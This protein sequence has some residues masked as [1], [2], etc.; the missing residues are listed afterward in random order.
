MRVPY[1]PRAS[2]ETTAAL[3]IA[4]AG[5]SS[6][7]TIAALL[8]ASSRVAP[9]IAVQHLLPSLV[10][11]SLALGLWVVRART[12]SSIVAR[13]LLG[14]AMAGA[15]AGYAV[16]QQL[17]HALLTSFSGEREALLG[18]LL[19]AGLG[20]ICL[21]LALE[22]VAARRDPAHSSRDVQLVNSAAW[23]AIVSAPAVVLAPDRRW[24]IVPMTIA[25]SAL[26]VGLLATARWVARRRWLRSVYG[27]RQSAWSVEP[28]VEHGT[29]LPV[30]ELSSEWSDERVVLFV[31]PRRGAA[32]RT[33]ERRIPVA[34]VV[35]AAPR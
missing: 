26:A 6:A 25:L 32:Y 33:T 14:G 7:T 1:S 10:L 9:Q 27:G 15:G 29:D 3:A 21:P 2:V 5:L 30:L 31:A 35:P 19:G 11:G 12:T 16:T 34:R 18:S 8:R 20:A 28:A 23:L 24:A 4:L 13:C 22:L 17:N